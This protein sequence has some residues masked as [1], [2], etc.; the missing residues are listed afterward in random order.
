MVQ[1]E[2]GRVFSA[3]TI[4]NVMEGHNSDLFPSNLSITKIYEFGEFCGS[5]NVTKLFKSEKGFHR[6]SLRKWD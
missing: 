3:R 6:E 4:E 5:D 1:Q 2:I